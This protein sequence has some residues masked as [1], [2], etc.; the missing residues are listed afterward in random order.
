MSR[1]TVVIACIGKADLVDMAIR[2]CLRQC[3]LR[4]II[5]VDGGASQETSLELAKLAAESNIVKVV[6]LE[7]FHGAGKARNIGV[8]HSTGEFLCFLEPDDE[9]LSDFLE[10]IVPLLDTH[11]EFSSIKVGIQ[12][13]DQNGLPLILPGDVRYQALMSSCSGN[14]I[15]RRTSFERLGGFS[16]DPRFIG[17]LAGEEGAFSRAVEDY[18]APVGYLPEAFYRRNVRPGS[19]ILQFLANTRVVGQ[20]VFEFFST[21]PE[22]EAHTILGQAID[23]YLEWVRNRVGASNQFVGD[24]DL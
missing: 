10:Q 20:D 3:L 22:Q 14:L 9:L 2:S 16:E 23:D 24:I 15:I 17:R 7:S 21:L 12:F 5:V 8:N 4:E 1:V 18:L 19:P 11:P 6:S 13:L